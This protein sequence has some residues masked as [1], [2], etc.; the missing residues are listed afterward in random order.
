MCAIAGILGLDADASIIRRMLATMR[1]RGP[2]A[3]GS[4]SDEDCHLLHAR[5]AVID[6]AGGAQPM[7]L[8]M[9]QDKYTIVYNGELYNTQQVRSVLESYG[10]QFQTHTDTEVVLH[11][12]AQWKEKSLEHLNGIFAFAVWEEG[13][14]RLFIARD[15]IGVKPLFYKQHENGF[16]LWWKYWSQS[17]IIDIT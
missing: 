3:A 10:H 6:L 15:R 1:R 13:S 7:S 12:Y 2:D 5:L 4:F 8:E 17:V 16:I 11:A 14:E 9:G